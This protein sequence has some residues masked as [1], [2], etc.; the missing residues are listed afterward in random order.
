MY[1]C[2]YI[3][4]YIYIFKYVHNIAFSGF[5]KCEVFVFQKCQICIFPTNVTSTFQSE[6]LCRFSQTGSNLQSYL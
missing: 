3:C 2:K 5:L 4:K 1:I 6:E